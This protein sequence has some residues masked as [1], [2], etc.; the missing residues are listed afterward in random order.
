MSSASTSDVELREGVREAASAG[1]GARAGEVGPPPESERE[2]GE[3]RAKEAA[4]AEAR[5]AALLAAERRRRALAEATAAADSA[6][7]AADA[8]EEEE[9]AKQAALRRAYARGPGLRLTAARTVFEAPRSHYF[10]NSV[11]LVILVNTIFLCLYRPTE[12][13]DSEWNTMLERADYFF[14]AAFTVEMVT[15]LLAGGPLMYFTDSWNL[16][17]FVVVVSAYLN[18]IPGL[19]GLGVS[20]L[21][22]VRVLRPLRTITVFPGL[23]LLVIT[24]ISALPMVGNVLVLAV[25]LFILFGI[26]GMQMFSG[27]LQ[28]RC[29][30][31]EEDGVTPALDEFGD[32]QVMEGAYGS[33]QMCS[34]LDV[35]AWEGYQCPSGYGC[36]KVGVNP[37]Y[38]C[39]SFD[40]LLWAFL[41]IFSCITLEEWTTIMYWTMDATSGWAC[42]YFIVLV[43]TGAFFVL[44]LAL[45]VVTNIHDETLKS[46]QSEQKKQDEAAAQSPTPQ[47][48]AADSAP[49]TVWS[50]TADA[51]RSVA[52]AVNCLIPNW[53]T[54]GALI[55]YDHPL[56]S[57]TGSTL[58]IVNTI[59][60]AMEY[61]G[62]SDLFQYILTLCNLALVIYFLLEMCIKMLAEGWEF[63]EDRFNV[64]DAIVNICSVIEIAVSS[65]GAMSALRSFRVLK[66]AAKW[67]SL[68]VFIGTMS[69]TLMALGD[70]L[71]VVLLVIFVFSLVGMQ[72][73]GD[74]FKGFNDDG[75]T[76]RPNF[77]TLF[78]SFIT[79]F[80]IL[81]GE[82]WNSVMYM[83][84]E[85]VGTSALMYYVLL[86][87]VGNFLVIN[88]FIAILLS[89][90]E[91]H[92]EE[93]ME[94]NRRERKLKKEAS[95]RQLELAMSPKTKELLAGAAAAVDVSEK[96]MDADVATTGTLDDIKKLE[97]GRPSP[98]L[99]AE[100]D[101]GGDISLDGDEEADEQENGAKPAEDEEG[102]KKALEDFTGKSFFL[103]DN[104]HSIRVKA[105]A[106]V[107]HPNFD[108]IILGFIVC[109]SLLMAIESPATQD[110]KTLT[111]FL[112]VADIV[113]TVLF[114]GEMIL[115]LTAYGCYGERGSYL[116]DSWNVCDG[117]IVWLSII[118]LSLT[119]QDIGWV[120]TMRVLRVLRPLR[121]IKRVPELKVV[122][123][124]LLASLPGLGHVLA[125]AGLFWLIFG[126]LGMALFM[127]KFG[128]CED[129]ATPGLTRAEC[130][131]AGGT[132]ARHDQ[133]FD[134]I[135]AAMC[136]LFEM[137]TTEGW[138]EIMFHGVDATG[139]DT[140]P[141]RNDNEAAALFFIAFMIIGCLFL[142]NLFVGIIMDNFDQKRK[143]LGRNL[144]LTEDQQQWIEAQQRFLSAN[145]HSSQGA[146]PSQRLRKAAYNLVTSDVFEVSIV[147]IIIIN[148]MFMASRHD[149]QSAEWSTTLDRLNV[150]FT[151]IYG[152]EAVLKIYG[153]SWNYVRELWNIFDFTIVVLSVVGMLTE[154]SIGAGVLRVLRVTRVLRLVRRLRSLAILFNTLFSSIATLLNVFML[155]MLVFFIYAVLGVNVFGEIRR[156]QEFLSEH[157]NFRN[158]G[159][160]MLTLF[161]MVTG[162]A[163]NGI[164]YDAMVEPPNCSRV[165]ESRDNG[166]GTPFAYAYFISFI[167]V[168]N[169]IMLNLFL[170]VVL[171]NYGSEK[172]KGPELLTEDDVANFKQLWATFDRDDT[173]FI[174]A[175]ELPV[176]LKKVPPPLGVAQKGVVP[177]HVLKELRLELIDGEF[178]FMQDLI[179]VLTQRVFGIKTE[180][181][182][183]EARSSVE[184]AASKMKFTSLQRKSEHR[185][186]H[187]GGGEPSP[188]DASSLSPGPAK[189][190]AF[191]NG[192]SAKLTVHQFLAAATIQRAVQCFLFRR[193]MQNLASLVR[194]HA[195]L[196]ETHTLSTELLNL[197]E[198]ATQ[199]TPL[200]PPPPNQK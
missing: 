94:E 65:G 125:V 32:Y 130:E 183:E 149:G 13:S 144:F 10:E 141:R 189:A 6:P 38:D 103:F 30:V 80:Q 200:P 8:D 153:L 139:R 177:K 118:N 135:L 151:A 42:L 88:L 85:A 104:Q 129:D 61:E 172:N 127:G 120:R 188:T 90:F 175:T 143:E 93:M 9:D 122:V 146:A 161:R 31:L 194:L 192:G 163:W 50:R 114:A 68:K 176:L 15:K 158:F 41:T 37:F 54:R 106:I 164:M 148:V 3:D 17:D 64:F 150:V 168:G 124:A 21:R 76:P 33:I 162:E 1:E 133:H 140:N 102:E 39:V 193:R 43:F 190:L 20:A 166:C 29:V 131:A 87:I 51:G 75:T 81:T 105:Y 165:N 34:N 4:A 157:A 152:V 159:M 156:D 22:V 123:N 12:P 154:I 169:F 108:S 2:E 136:T 134:N 55:V 99:A 26:L 184:S 36:V 84:K 174:H 167:V 197:F 195:D 115:K 179:Q 132:W 57:T 98:L 187:G 173:G 181:V 107:S 121:M 138:L 86:V 11:F 67:P 101:C 97:A 79:V 35:A 91:Q 196:E 180:D 155:L 147:V 48:A 23:R 170:A 171:E 19:E 27:E 96:E 92:R 56:F 70:F 109:S 182:P 44:N 126:I 145:S 199:K 116:H 117:I 7:D 95:R 59:V 25:Y 119:G 52:A 111:A 58:L 16:L 60:L 24:I 178:V 82:N 77:D 45:A 73:F 18:L 191:N 40:H 89:S 137:S 46:E 112:E 78:W 74:K 71:V 62:M 28:K 185:G 100:E 198:G 110:N 186:R 47:G 14:T 83:S 69:K 66:L 49:P 142:V 5:A 53:L 72:L 128:Y 113:F 63:M 160:A